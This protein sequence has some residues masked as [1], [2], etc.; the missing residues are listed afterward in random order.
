LVD[1][2]PELAPPLEAG[3]FSRDGPVGDGHVGRGVAADDHGVLVDFDGSAGRR[4]E[5]K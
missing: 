4:D 5:P 2:E 1:D 3:V